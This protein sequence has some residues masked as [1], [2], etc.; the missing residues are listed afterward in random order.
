MQAYVKQEFTKHLTA[1]CHFNTQTKI[2]EEEVLVR[3]T[4]AFIR[5]MKRIN[6]IICWLRLRQQFAFPL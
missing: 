1:R 3:E 6:M 2:E 4:N 5:S